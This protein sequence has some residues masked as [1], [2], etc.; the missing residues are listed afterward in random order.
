MAE[1]HEVVVHQQPDVEQI[2][3]SEQ[4]HELRLTPI[5]V[6]TTPWRRCMAEFYLS[7]IHVV[8]IRY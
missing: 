2:P 3:R 4:Q 8:C 5:L 6:N 1:A 7:V